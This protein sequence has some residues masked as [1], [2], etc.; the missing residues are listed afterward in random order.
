MASQASKYLPICFAV[1]FMSAASMAVTYDSELNDAIQK[2]DWPSVVLLLQPKKGQNFEHDLVLAKALL[3]LERRPEALKLLSTL[4]E[5]RKDERLSKLFQ[6]AGTIFFAQETSNLYYEAVDFIKNSKFVEAKDRLDQAILKEPGQV[7]L[8][9]RLTQLELLSDKKELAATHLKLAQANSL[10][11]MELKLFAAKIAVDRKPFNS[12]DEPESIYELVRVLSPL[13]AQLL[14]NEVTLTYWGEALKRA[15]KTVELETL[16]VKT[17][18]EHPAWTYSLQWLRTNGSFNSALDEKLR[19]R[20]DQNLKDKAAFLTAL[21]SEM[22]ATDYLWAGYVLYDSLLLQAKPT[23]TP[24]PT[25][26]PA[27]GED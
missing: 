11:L 20:I 6:S 18:K 1:F 8:L 26:V 3:S 15:Q 16:A 9:T 5:T 7:L 13:R 2:K 14:E 17:L 19:V 22:K 10:G 25:P 4:S 27:V 21:E 23:P 12:D 24:V